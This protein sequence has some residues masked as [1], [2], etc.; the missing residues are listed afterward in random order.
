MKIICKSWWKYYA[1]IGENVELYVKI[2]LILTQCGCRL[3]VVVFLDCSHM[4]EKVTLCNVLT[5][6]TEFYPGPKMSGSHLIWD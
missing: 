5:N 3:I 4:L 2:Q 1:Q 6:Q